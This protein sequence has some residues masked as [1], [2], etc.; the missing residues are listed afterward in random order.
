MSD[1]VTGGL[2]RSTTAP[3]VLASACA[4]AAG[5]IV[6]SP[7][8]AVAPRAAEPSTLAATA[9]AAQAPASSQGVATPRPRIDW[10]GVAGQILGVAS[11]IMKCADYSTN[12]QACFKNPTT[13][14]IMRKLEQ[15]EAQMVRNQAE[16]MRALDSLQRSLDSQDL[17]RAVKDFSPVE[18]HIFEAADAWTALSECAE[19][20]ASGVLKDCNGYNGKPTAR[21]PISEA[22]ALTQEFFL[23]EMGKIG[24]SIEQSAQYFA[25]SRS[26]NYQDG[27]TAALWKS[28]KREQDRQSGARSPGELPLQPV[29]VTRFLSGSVL[30]ALTYYRDMVF[31]YGALRPA[32]KALKGE[33]SRAQSE[34]NLADKVIFSGGNRGTVAGAFAFYRIPDVSPGTI[35]FVGGNGKLYKILPG[36][37]KGTPLSSAVLQDLGARLHDYGYDAGTMAKVGA[38]LPHGG[39]FGVWEKVRHR[40]YP[41][42]SG[43]YAICAGVNALGCPA[44]PNA[45]VRTQTFELGDSAA[46]GS[47]DEY[48]NVVKMR[49][50]PMQVVASKA[51]WDKLVESKYGWYGGRSTDATPPNGVWNVQPREV[52]DRTVAGKFAIFSYDFMEYSQRYYFGAGVYA[53]LDK[54]Q[55]F[56]VVDKGTPAG[57]LVK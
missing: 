19:R 18:A 10:S 49:W 5:L 44:S 35:A 7:A 4:L 26:T 12:P 3:V 50:V 16:T 43:K 40:S 25:G 9:P 11:T 41:Y 39:K 57:I 36:E 30:P 8:A 24:L 51:T 20:A 47:K 14:D 17:N 46:V 38:L 34:A 21:L 56:V 28:A 52:F 31:L 13:K 54:G 32:A 27:L 48:G 45:A 53:S 23:D 6:G 42:Y 1:N 33:A 29:V 55:P 15:I 22:M 2:M 37:G